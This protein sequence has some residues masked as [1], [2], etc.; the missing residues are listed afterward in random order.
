MFKVILRWLIGD[1]GLPIKVD[2]TLPNPFD[3]GYRFF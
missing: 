1:E 2:N 3:D